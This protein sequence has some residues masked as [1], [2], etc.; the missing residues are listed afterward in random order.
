MEH[1]VTECAMGNVDAVQK[2]LERSTHPVDA[3][4]MAKGLQ[5]RNIF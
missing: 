3:K 4:L 5:A 2:M 1:F